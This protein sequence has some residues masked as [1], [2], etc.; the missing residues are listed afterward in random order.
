MTEHQRHQLDAYVP[1]LLHEW[2]EAVRTQTVEGSLVHIDISGFTAMSERLAAKGRQGAEEV[3]GVLTT[4]FTEL[5]GIAAGLGADMLKFGGDAL[6]LLFTGSRHAERAVRASSEMRSRLRT[7][8]KINTPAGR[9][10]L[11]MTVGVHSG[12]LTMFLVGESHRELIVTGTGASTVVAMEEAATAGQIMMSKATAD[13]LPAGHVG[14]LKRGGRL[15]QKAVP[16]IEYE[17][18]ETEERN[19]PAQFLPAAIREIAVAAQ[20]EGEHRIVTVAFVKFHRTDELLARDGPDALCTQLEGLVT[21]VQQ[22]AAE[23]G[24]TFLASDIDRDGGKIILTAGAPT[25]TGNDDERMLRAVRHIMDTYHGLPIRIGVNRGP[26]FTGDVGAPFRRTF[27]VI[28][29]AVNL[30]AR[31]MAKA[32]DGQILSTA[33]ALAHSTTEFE[34]TPVEPFM[35]KGKRQPV[36]ASLVGAAAGRRSGEHDEIRFVGRSE[37]L[38]Q[39]SAAL[40]GTPNAALIDVVGPS[41]IGKSRFV[42]ELRSGRDTRPWHFSAAEQ[43]E[44]STPYYPYQQLLREV[45]AIA[46][47][48]SPEASLHALC[49]AVDSLAPELEPWVPLLAAVL[50][51]PAPETAETANLAPEFRTPRIHDTVETLLTAVLAEPAALIIEDA[52]WMDDASRD[53]TA[54]LAAR[55]SECSWTVVTVRRPSDL[56]LPDGV[57]I[58]LG[59]MTPEE[60]AGLAELALGDAPMLA[61][62]LQAVVDRA[63]GNPLYLLQLVDAA[64]SQADDE[65]PDSVE[66]LVLA[67]IDRLAPMH[68]KLLR[69]ASVAGTTFDPELLIDAVEDLEP[70]VADP[71]NWSALGEFI[72]KRK[73]GV[74][75]FRQELFHAVAY[76]GLPYRTRKLLHARV[77]KAL[78]K[79]ARR[80]GEDHAE[81]LSVHFMRAD[82]FLKAWRYSV[83]AGDQAKEKYGNAD[84]VDFYDRALKAA[85]HLDLPDR[86]IAKVA[87]TFGDVAELCGLYDT[88]D[89]AFREARDHAVA[90]TRADTVPR[91]MRKQGMLREKRGAYSDALRWFSRGLNGLNG[92]AGREAAELRLAYAGVRFRQARYTDTIEWAHEALRLAKRSR[93]RGGVAHAYSLLGLA[94]RR[95]G[96][97]QALEFLRDALAIYTDIGDLVGQA[98]SLNN[99]GGADYYMGEWERASKR[100]ET[101]TEVRQRAGDAV[102]AAMAENNI[103]NIR[104]DQGRLEEAD[105][106]FRHVRREL[107]AAGFSLGVAVVTSNLGRVAAR[108]GHFER[109]HEELTHALED[110]EAMGAG[111]Y[112]LEAKAHV[113]EAYLFEGHIED[114]RQ[115]AS[116]VLDDL[117]GKAGS[118]ELGALLL[119]LIGY[120][121]LI[122][123]DSDT[124]REWFTRSL[125]LAEKAEAH[126]E[127]ALTLDAMAHVSGDETAKKD[128]CRRAQRI[129]DHLGVVAVPE[130]PLPALVP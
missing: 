58:E 101:C 104:S 25:A 129:F 56:Q 125:R 72:V 26:A 57:V 123:G 79:R 87:E 70:A 54:F 82:E 27:T 18:P 73:S 88:A 2:P 67:R 30:S 119:R 9:V 116:E 3:A 83:A 42:R 65:L 68:R 77:G 38:Q 48:T 74:L 63:G 35:V 84:A 103:A 36:E 1:R 115:L 4:V 28:G 111:Q 60:S 120:S 8:G 69:Y 130:I 43:F 112:V 50:D 53:L 90:G 80:T 47:N 32:G 16:P 14:A 20:G 96:S 100:W 15:L 89:R 95:M 24:V 64:S 126:Y 5:L 22:A 7:V 114:C 6:L 124:A 21:T 34:A 13:A 39:A 44:A 71:K 92:A 41:G 128:S 59:P 122:K 76:S 45:L 99:L 85:R 97:D 17:P 81:R 11:R 62:R 49:H 98:N 127:T 102:G 29:D 33:G 23:Y 37:A 105:V 31:V 86:D 19:P 109:A 117:E 110:L 12:D 121:W 78:E 93:D 107:R 108:A 52:H 46:P 118:H 113:A 106:M 91:L 10:A 61:S 40:E 55:G 51:I 75:R 66:G 94:H